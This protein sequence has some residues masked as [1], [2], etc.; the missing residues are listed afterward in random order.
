MQHELSLSIFTSRPLC[1]FARDSIIQQI[2]APLPDSLHI[3]IKLTVFVSSFR[4]RFIPKLWAPF[5]IRIPTQFSVYT[6]NYWKV[7][8]HCVDLNFMKYLNKIC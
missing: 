2:N 3:K 1:G 4:S 8:H 6:R 7:I 5:A